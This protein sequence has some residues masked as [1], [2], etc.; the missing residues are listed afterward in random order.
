[1][2]YE[3]FLEYVKAHVKNYLPEM[4]QSATVEITKVIKNNDIHL[5]SLTITTDQESMQGHVMI[6]A[7]YLNQYYQNYMDRGNLEVT[8]RTIALDYQQALRQAPEFDPDLLTDYN[9]AKD[10]II[11]ALV[12]TA[13][14]KERLQNLPHQ[15]IGGMSAIYKIDVTNSPL[16]Q[17]KDE[18]GATVSVTYEMMEH[19]GVTQEEL[20]QTALRNSQR[21]YPFMLKGLMETM[22]YPGGQ[23]QMYVLSNKSGC[24]GAAVML[25]PGVMESVMDRL[26]EVYILPSSTHEVLLVPRQGME[27]ME[28]ELRRMVREVNQVAVEPQEVLGN[29]IYTYNRDTKQIQVVEPQT[30]QVKLPFKQHKPR[31]L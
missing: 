19:F 14:N 31:T 11:V 27:G 8:M 30:A 17:G 13:F 20:H 16:R 28:E 12:N 2:I 21:L 22:G 10:Y 23:E 5:D 3:E 25:Y 1:M 24:M 9:Q 18:Y 29:D 15:D 4:Y 26:G 6:P 7:L